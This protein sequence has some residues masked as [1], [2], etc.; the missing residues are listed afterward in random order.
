VPGKALRGKV[1]HA[2]S[3]TIADKAQVRHD[4]KRRRHVTV[5][6]LMGPVRRFCILSLAMSSSTIMSEMKR[7]MFT[8]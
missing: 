4:A 2:D 1:L 5:D 7:L 3:R 6:A 8:G